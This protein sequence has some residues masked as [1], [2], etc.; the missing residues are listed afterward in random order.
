MR[1]LYHE[2]A[3]LQS[4]FVGIVGEFLHRVLLHEI[5]GKLLHFGEV[6]HLQSVVVG[7]GECKLQYESA[8]RRLLIIGSDVQRVLRYEDV[9][10]DTTTSIHR[11]AYRRVIHLARVLNAVLREEFSVLVSHEDVLL[12]ALLVAHGVGFLY[13]SSRGSVVAC[14]GEPYHRPVVEWYGLLHE[15]LA[16]RAS[17]DDCGTVVV[18]HCAGED[19]RSRCR[20]LVDEHH[21]W[22][23]LIRSASVAA[24]FLS[25]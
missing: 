24:V 19:F 12:V 6:V 18:L 10:S 16:K 3:S 7:I 15:S 13:A 1:L 14:D 2:V 20:T 5:V 9:G 11:S 8:H 17:S 21:E 25:G 23:L 4:V 22:Y